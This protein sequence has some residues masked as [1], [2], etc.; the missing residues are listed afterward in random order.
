[1]GIIIGLSL[2]VGLAVIFG[3]WSSVR[4]AKNL[5]RNRELLETVT[6][7]DRG[8]W[9]ERDLVLG[10]LKSGIPAQTI[11]HDLYV[12]K[13]NGG[14]SQIDVVVATK[15]G[16]IVFEVKDYSG[17]IFGNG[18]HTQWTQVLAYGKRK[19]RFYNP[20]MQNKG[21]IAQLRKR[22]RQFEKVP[23][24]SVI[25]FYGDCE[26]KDISFVPKGTF[27]VRPWRV[28]DVVWGIINGNEPAG[29]TDKREVVTVLREAVKNGAD[30]GT[31][32]R[33]IENVKDMLGKER[34]FE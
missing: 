26:L 27:I 25:V 16:I 31:E 29:Y 3:I 30:A 19:Y 2:V 12:R 4:Q 7:L 23:F 28:L 15:A 21:H 6:A 20:I 17:W 32:I 34:I 11:F 9:A 14:F 33:H 13:R 5:Q 10:L 1:M 8:T 18:N 24:Y 22:L